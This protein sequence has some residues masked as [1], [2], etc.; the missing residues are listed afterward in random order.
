M[1]IY[2]I[3]ILITFTI[4]NTGVA[5]YNFSGFVHQEHTSVEVYLSLIEDYRQLSGVYPEQIIQ[6]TVCDSTGYFSFSGDNLPVDNRIYKI[7]IENCSNQEQKLVHFDGFCP[8][9]KEILFIAHNKDSISLPFSFD[10]EVFCKVVSSNEK[11]DAFIKVDSIVEEMRFA[12]TTYR[13]ETNRKL[14]SQK[15]FSTLQ[16]YAQETQEPLVGL[17]VYAFVSNKSNRLHSFYLKDLKN[18]SFYQEVLAQLKTVYPNSPYTTQYES[19]LASDTFIALPKQPNRAS[20]WIWVLVGLLII[21]LTF[22]MY[23]YS[24]SKNKKVLNAI[25][26]QLTQQ[27]EKVLQLILNNKTNKEIASSMFVSVSTVKTHINN[28]YKKLK[29]SSRDE[30]K[31]LYIKR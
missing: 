27:E 22:N 6:K 25:E 5:Q 15:W 31:S 2:F 10:T 30:V 12:F 18:N 24:K 3:I 26:N 14:N 16:K 28:L 19:E 29:V 4:C 11:S 21:S 20:Y 13:S 8:D 7:H 17:Y 1:R 23:Q 9:S